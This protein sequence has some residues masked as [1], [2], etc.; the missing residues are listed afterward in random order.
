MVWAYANLGLLV[1]PLF[2][3]MSALAVTPPILETFSPQG[4]ANVF[5]GFAKFR[6]DEPRVYDALLTHSVRIGMGH[7]NLGGVPGMGRVL[8]PVLTPNR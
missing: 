6:V 3:A 8:G 5:W 2:G 7:P 1:P 4:V